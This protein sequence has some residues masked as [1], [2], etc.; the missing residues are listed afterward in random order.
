MKRFLETN[1]KLFFKPTRH[2]LIYDHPPEPMVFLPSMPFLTEHLQRIN[3][4]SGNL[5]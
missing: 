3:F 5:Q 4:G 2:R 1:E